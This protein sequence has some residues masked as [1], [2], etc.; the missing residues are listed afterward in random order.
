MKTLFF[1][2]RLKIS[3]SLIYYVFFPKFDES[4]YEVLNDLF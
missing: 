4:I 1:G 2:G 3:T